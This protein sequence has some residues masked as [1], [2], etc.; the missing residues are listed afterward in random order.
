MCVQ[1]CKEYLSRSTEGRFILRGSKEG[2]QRLMN[3]YSSSTCGDT[4]TTNGSPSTQSPSEVGE[5]H[6]GDA[7][8]EVDDIGSVIDVDELIWIDVS[9]PLPGHQHMYRNAVCWTCTTKC[10]ADAE[11]CLLIHLAP[12]GSAFVCFLLQ[13]R[14]WIPSQ[15]CLS[16]LHVRVPSHL[17]ALTWL[18]AQSLQA[19]HCENLG[20]RA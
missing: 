16:F 8:A 15:I 18:I 14:S 9:C 2:Y 5:A 19:A 10:C 13:A 7:S 3:C 1:A 4:T 17:Q 6:V 12:A 11:S 20:G